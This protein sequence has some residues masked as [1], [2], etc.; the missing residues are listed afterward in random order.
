M[1]QITD[2]GSTPGVNVSLAADESG[3]KRRYCGF[4]GGG[5]IKVFIYRGHKN[6]Y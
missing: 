5:G 1:N 6:R 2:D 4:A 3:G